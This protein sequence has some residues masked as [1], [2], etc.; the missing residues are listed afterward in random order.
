MKNASRIPAKISCGSIRAIILDCS[1]AIIAA[2]IVKRTAKNTNTD[3]CSRAFFTTTNVTPQ[4][5]EH[6]ASE[7]SACS[8]RFTGIPASHKKCAAIMRTNC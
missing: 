6:N 3:D 5:S 7:R 8:L 4:I 1:K 2:A